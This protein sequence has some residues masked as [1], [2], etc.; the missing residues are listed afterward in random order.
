MVTFKMLFA[1]GVPYNQAFEGM[2]VGMLFYRTPA[3]HASQSI[4]FL[5]L[6]SRLECK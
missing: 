3:K 5:E 1:L 6:A 2:H 4:V